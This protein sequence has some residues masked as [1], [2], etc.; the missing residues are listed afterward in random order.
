MLT[1][2]EIAQSL[3]LEIS[4]IKE[5]IVN[6]KLDIQSKGQAITLPQIMELKR[7]AET[8]LYNGKLI[9]RD[10]SNIFKPFSGK[11]FNKAR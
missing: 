6:N 3:F 7:K 11:T 10:L 2:M 4:E 9:L 5:K 1:C 8:F